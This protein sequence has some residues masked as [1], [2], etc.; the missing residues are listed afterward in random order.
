MEDIKNKIKATAEKAKQK[1]D[2]SNIQEKLKDAADKAQQKLE[3]SNIQEKVGETLNK[4]NAD[5][6]MT[7][8]KNAKSFLAKIVAKVNV[9]AKA[10]IIGFIAVVTV[11]TAV[12]GASVLLGGTESKIVMLN[13]NKINYVYNENKFFGEAIDVEDG[14]II[15]IK[16]KKLVFDILSLKV[17]SILQTKNHIPGKTNVDFGD[18]N[19]VVT[20]KNIMFGGKM[21]VLF[22]KAI[23]TVGEEKLNGYKVYIVDAEAKKVYK[24]F[25]DSKIIFTK[26]YTKED[27]QK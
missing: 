26:Y 16:P 15:K 8:A 17:D 23:F 6:I 24:N 12:V 20:V 10:V 2:E 3:E 13:G 14:S 9:S 18:L 5:M 21:E 4:E 19:A 22:Q 1:L 7:K 25:P 27:L 11:L